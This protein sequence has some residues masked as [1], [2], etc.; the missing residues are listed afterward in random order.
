MRNAGCSYPR[1]TDYGFIWGPVEVERSVFERDSVL[2][3]LKT[4]RQ[5]L[6]VRVTST[7]LIRVGEPARR[8]P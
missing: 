4:D 7:G 6:E 2:L 5:I 8:Q 1:A 3:T